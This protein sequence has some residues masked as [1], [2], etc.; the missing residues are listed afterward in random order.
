MRNTLPVAPVQRFVG[1]RRGQRS[2][3]NCSTVNPASRA[4][5]PIVKALTGLCRGMVTMRTPSD[6]TICLPWRMM[7]KSAFWSARTAS[8][9]LTPGIFGTSHRHRNFANVLAFDEVVYCGEVFA[10]GVLNVFEGLGF[11]SP[12]RP[13]TWKTRTRNAEAF[14]RLMNDDLVIHVDLAEIIRLRMFWKPS[15]GGVDRAARHRAASLDHA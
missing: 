2:F 1:W 6:I 4:I 7:R 8:R 15:N 3:L 11:C 12:L 10:N 9:W 13:A 5:P 14:L